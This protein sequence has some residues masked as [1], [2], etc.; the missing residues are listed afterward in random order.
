MTGETKLLAGK[1]AFLT[2]AGSGIGRAGALKLAA[3]GARLF[4]TD[5]DPE[6]ARATAGLIRDAGGEAVDHGLDV[7][8]F[9]AVDTLLAACLKDFGRIDILH[10]HA[11][12]QIAG[13]AESL[14]IADFEQSL[15]V[16]LMAQFVAAKAVIPLMKEQGGGVILNSSSNAG[17]F[18]DWAML[19]YTTSK[20]AVI[21]LTRQLALDYGGCGIRVNALCPGWVDTPFNLPYQNHLGGREALEQV[22]RTKVPLGRFGRLDE[23][24]DAIL[25]LV[26]PMSSYVTGHALVVDGGESLAAAASMGAPA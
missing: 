14:S 21:T 4:V 12:V 11:G 2:A 5:R 9:A 16:N 20:A 18:L 26:S 19:A 10:N 3:S 25:F 22:V 6:A 23:L 24:A 15:R 17:L 7:T 13:S 1:V 8:S